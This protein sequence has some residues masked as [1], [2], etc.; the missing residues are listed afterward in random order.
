MVKADITDL[1]SCQ[2]ACAGV[3]YVLHQAAVGRSPARSRNPI[4]THQSN[5]D[6]SS[7]FLSA[8]KDAKVKRF[9]YASSSSVY[10]ESSGVAQS[11]AYRGQ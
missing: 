3:D 11:G 7:I 6:G 8:A 10:G 2:R 4:L 9:V 1:D 5:V